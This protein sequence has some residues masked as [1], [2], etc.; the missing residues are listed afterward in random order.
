[1]D[2]CGFF[3]FCKGGFPLGVAL[4]RYVEPLVGADLQDVRISASSHVEVLGTAAVAVGDH[5]VVHPAVWRGFNDERSLHVLVHELAHVAQQRAGRVLPRDDGI[6]FDDRLESEAEWMADRAIGR[7]GSSNPE[8]RGALKVLAP[9]PRW[10]QGLA[11]QPHPGSVVIRRALTWLSGRSAKAISKHIA[12]HAT[13]NF[14]KS[15]HSVFR[16]I[17]KIR[18]LVKQTL[19]EGASLAEHFAQS[20]GAQAVERAGVKVTRQAT[21]T[22]GKFRWL[23]QKKFS[24][25]IG[26]NGETVLRVV[27]DM[28]GRIVTAF[29][30]DKLLTIL[31]TVTAA[32]MLTA[33]IAD[34]AEEIAAEVE[35]LERL[36]EMERNKIDLW[37]FVPGIG[38]IWGGALNQFEDLEMAHDR[39]VDRRIRDIIAAAERRAGCSFANRSGLEDL[40]RC[41]VGI[42][43]LLEHAA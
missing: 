35:R 43:L 1:M 14:A 22:P 20:S 34:A 9:V 6:A 3:E 2:A 40:V 28:S 4:R 11:L 8:F 29:P 27:L 26:T 24:G 19:T 41:G 31:V 21:G 17:D 7:L 37:D 38:L 32:E 13:R 23:I 10:L 36:K 33:G 25:A 18:P 16:S 42:P 5:I 15:I 12:A 39:Y 30:A